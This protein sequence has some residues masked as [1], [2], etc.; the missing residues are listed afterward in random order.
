MV[1]K[2]WTGELVLD[3]LVLLF[4]YE[5]G[6]VIVADDGGYGILQGPIDGGDI[7]TA[8]ARVLPVYSLRW[9]Y[10]YVRDGKEPLRTNALISADT[11]A[12]FLNSR[13]SACSEPTV[14]I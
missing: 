11:I 12:L 14:A 6:F 4:G 7:L 2:E 10:A 1:S 3:R 5:P 9:L 13:I 8:A